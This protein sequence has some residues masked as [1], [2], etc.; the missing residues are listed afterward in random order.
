MYDNLP[1]NEKTLDLDI[2]GFVTGVKYQGQFIVKCI[3]DIAGNH[4]LEME[5]TRLQA[6]Y[7]NPTDG[8]AGISEYLAE[9]R[10]RTI[11][12]PDWWTNNSNGYTII[13]QNVLI[14]IFNKCKEAEQQWK[15]DLKKLSDKAQKGNKA[16]ESTP[17]E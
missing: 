5:K 13:D 10:A 11:K 7:A 3:L 1:K 17:K 15:D 16:E 9:I 14:Q 12:A 6:D 2:E 4:A 8:L